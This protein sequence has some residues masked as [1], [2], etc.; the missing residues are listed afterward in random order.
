MKTRA[1][2]ASGMWHCF[3]ILHWNDL[4]DHL[5]DAPLDCSKRIFY[6]QQKKFCQKGGSIRVWI[7]MMKKRWFLIMR[8]LRQNLFKFPAPKKP[9]SALH[10]SSTVDQF[11]HD[12][13]LSYSSG[14]VL[15][16]NVHCVLGTLNTVLRNK[17][18]SKLAREFFKQRVETAF[19][20]PC[21]SKTKWHTV[22]TVRI[23]K[24][25]QHKN[26]KRFNNKKRFSRVIITK[27]AA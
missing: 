3:V 19:G 22:E 15:A 12:N 21:E 17:A 25:L 13:C 18:T 1:K 10:R 16:G 24:V 2:D 7:N 20:E 23:A 6:N 9:H 5:C 26:K 14:A 11:G 4:A 8:A 27:W